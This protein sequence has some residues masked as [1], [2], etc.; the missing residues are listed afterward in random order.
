MPQRL[1]SMDA[2][3]GFVMLL[4]AGEMVRFGAVAANMP[5]DSVWHFSRTI[6]IMWIGRGARSM[7]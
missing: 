7:T 3:R 6:R 1:S 4:M 5:A 2:Y